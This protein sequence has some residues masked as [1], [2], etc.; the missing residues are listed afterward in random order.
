MAS[1]CR[2]SLP[3]TRPPQPEGAQAA[4]VPIAGHARSWVKKG[5]ESGMEVPCEPGTWGN[6]QS[7]PG[8]MEMR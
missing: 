1:Y 6:A 3:T 5:K 7:P 2:C 8:S 4:R